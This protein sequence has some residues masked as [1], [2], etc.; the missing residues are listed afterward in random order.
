MVTA[1]IQEGPDKGFWFSD[2]SGGLVSRDL[3]GPTLAAGDVVRFQ[4][5]GVSNTAGTPTVRTTEGLSI[6]A[7]GA[8]VRAI[9]G[10]V[11]APLDFDVH[12]LDFVEVVGEVVAGP[13]DCRAI[14]C[15]TI[16]Y[17]GEQIELRTAE[18]DLHVGDSVRYAGP[19][20]QSD[21]VEEL[22]VL[23]PS[24]LTIE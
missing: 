3:S 23:D 15:Y 17:A 13:S 16:A 1:V 22:D 8:P 21:G 20:S 12:G 4:V 19:L 11:E 24:W 9:D 10:N 14:T 7:K 6:L 18:H 2:V 5:S